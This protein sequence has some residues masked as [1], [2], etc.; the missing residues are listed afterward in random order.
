MREN[1]AAYAV[2]GGNLTIT[3]EP[4]DI[5]TADTTPPPNNFILQSADHAGADWVIETK[6]DSG[7]DGGYGQGGLIAMVNGDN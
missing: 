5:Y 7:V 1:P 3:T 6:I 4:G 2:G